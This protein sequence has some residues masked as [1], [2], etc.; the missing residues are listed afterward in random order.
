MSSLRLENNVDFLKSRLPW[1][2]EYKNKWLKDDLRQK[3]K[4]TEFQK[5][6]IISDEY[7]KRISPIYE[8][9]NFELHMLTV[10]N[11]RK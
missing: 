7:W 2:A 3:N 1:H 8:S 6:F 11:E 9:M 4:Q 10:S 5:M